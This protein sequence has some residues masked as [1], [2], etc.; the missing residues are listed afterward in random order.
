MTR[1]YRA[2]LIDAV[3]PGVEACLVTPSRS[4][5]AK[6]GICAAFYRAIE[7]GLTP[8]RRPVCAPQAAKSY[9]GKGSADNDDTLFDARKLVKIFSA[10]LRLVNSPAA[11]TF[12]K[13]C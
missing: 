1:Q 12:H 8:A 7:S 4:P 5:H 6:T 11:Q 10:P 3:S 2:V 9:R 13:S